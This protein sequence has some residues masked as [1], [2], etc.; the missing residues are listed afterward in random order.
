MTQTKRIKYLRIALMAV[1]L[2][3]VFALYPLT[4]LWPSG[5]GGVAMA[6]RRRR[7]P[8]VAGAPPLTL[9]TPKRFVTQQRN[10]GARG[11]SLGSGSLLR[12]PRPLL[13]HEPFW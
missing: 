7:A 3:F 5:W 6:R 9:R 8:A 4:V 11:T 12:W 2:I 1:G 10:H 13:T